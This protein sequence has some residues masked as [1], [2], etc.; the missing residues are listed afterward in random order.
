MQLISLDFSKSRE[1]QC[2]HCALEDG[3]KVNR[4][5]SYSLDKLAEDRGMATEAN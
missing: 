3:F 4:G 2:E 1:K 5:A